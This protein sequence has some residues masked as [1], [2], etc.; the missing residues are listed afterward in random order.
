MFCPKCGTQLPDGSQ[1]CSE[2]GASIEQPSA[3]IPQPAVQPAQPVQPEQPAQTFG[4]Q[5]TYQQQQFGEQPQFGAQPAYAAPVYG[6][7]AVK[8]K[9]PVVPIVC[10]VV[11]AA[12]VAFL[13]VLFVVIIPNN[14]GVKGKLRHEWLYD[15]EDII[16]DLKHNKVKPADNSLSGL[17]GI[18]IS[19]PL[20]WSVDGEDRL[21]VSMSMMGVSDEEEYLISFSADGKTLTLADPDYPSYKITWTRVD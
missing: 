1:F 12:I 8:K 20:S 7:P 18:D 6:Q 21:T 19:F 13:I 17:T 2:C 15:D 14:T 10:G 3:Q 16:I 4:A 11:G 5:P 9:V